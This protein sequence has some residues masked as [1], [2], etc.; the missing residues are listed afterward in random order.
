MKPHLVTLKLAFLFATIIFITG[1]IKDDDLRMDKMSNGE[2][3]PEFA[4]PLV[5]SDLSLN[6]IIGVDENGLFT[7]NNHQL[8]LIYKTNIYTQYG[9]QFFTPVSQSNLLTLQMT[10][11]DTAALYQNGSVNRSI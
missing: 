11:M 7:V 5:N 9:Y 8:S 1:C 10:P 3:S 4:V 2:W 6:D